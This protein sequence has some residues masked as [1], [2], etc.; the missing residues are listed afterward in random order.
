[1]QLPRFQNGNIKDTFLISNPSDGFVILTR[2]LD[3][4]EGTR[5]FNLEI[6]AEVFKMRHF[7]LPKFC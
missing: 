7:Y 5:E 2:P 4:D 6:K 1:M 3:Y